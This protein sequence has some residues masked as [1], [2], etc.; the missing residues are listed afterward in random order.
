MT[1]ELADGLEPVWREAIAGEMPLYLP[2]HPTSQ[3]LGSAITYA[4]RYALTAVLNLV[5]DEDDDGHSASSAPAFAQKRRANE[6][7]VPKF[8]DAKADNRKEA[9]KPQKGRVRGEAT[10]VG[11]RADS[12]EWMAFTKHEF[13]QPVNVDKLTFDQAS[14]LIDRLPKGAI[15]TGESDVPSDDAPQ[16]EKVPQD[17]TL[18]FS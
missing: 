15:P 4:R 8:Y 3:T 16:H 5:A 1:G 2:E 11:V 9:T 13:G 14:Y 12:R 10:K 6:G 18:P 7:V 17:D